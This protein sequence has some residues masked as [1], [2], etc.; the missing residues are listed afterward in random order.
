METAKRNTKFQIILNKQM[1]ISL[2]KSQSKGG[3]FLSLYKITTSLLN[4]VFIP[5]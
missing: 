2:M 4:K 1:S 5:T 3:L